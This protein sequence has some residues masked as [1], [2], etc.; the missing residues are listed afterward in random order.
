MHN[1]IRFGIIDKLFFN[2]GYGFINPDGDCENIF[3]LLSKVDYEIR[4]TLNIGSRVSFKT[5]PSQMHNDKNEAY[6][7]TVCERKSIF[8]H[9]NIDKL[10]GNGAAEL[11]NPQVLKKWYLEP[12]FFS[13]LKGGVPIRII[14]G[15]KGVGKTALFKALIEDNIAEDCIPILIKPDEIEDLSNSSDDYLEMVR[16][17][18]S[19]LYTIITHK[20]I[21]YSNEKATS[22]IA[23]EKL[24]NIGTTVI[25]YLASVL[26]K[27]SNEI[28]EKRFSVNSDQFLNMLNQ[29]F[30][31]Q[32]YIYVYLDD[33]D[34]GWSSSNNGT[35]SLNAMIN[36]LM[37]IAATN[38]NSNIRFRISITSVVYYSIKAF[39]HMSDKIN[40]NV[41]WMQ[42][43]K[44]DIAKMLAM[45]IHLFFNKQP[46]NFS[47][48][49]VEN[50]FNL[51]FEP[52]FLENGKWENVPFRQVI[53]SVVRDRPRDIIQLC[54]FAANEA[55]KNGHNKIATEDLANIFKQ[56]SLEKLQDAI[57]EFKQEFNELERLINGLKPDEAEIR[58]KDNP[59]R[60]TQNQLLNKLA[61][62]SEH[63]PF[64]YS[65]KE[66]SQEDLAAVL[67][68]TGFINACRERGN[69]IERVSYDMNRYIYNEF[70]RGDFLYEIDPAYRFAMVPPFLSG[71]PK[72]YLG[73][74]FESVK[75]FQRWRERNN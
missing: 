22:L 24:R 63:K 60:F 40:E 56:Y 69:H 13:H 74:E 47:S 41:I 30:F 3:F 42:W 61:K 36:A 35:Q 15:N 33:L 64:I 20:L 9:D 17:W 59:W 18:K 4:L 26:E 75:S 6:C 43:T 39:N 12:D 45:R 31:D 73:P 46:A 71:I 65:G 2:R 62:I 58:S 44:P 66:A 32:K 52:N 54:K 7:I 19:G 27:K 72:V 57:L 28:V 11:E 70:T 37:D 8:S 1:D 34:R 67:Y 29:S 14:A 23:N 16:K 51:I 25:T 48:I 50:I 10:F 53:L 5:R 38:S 68:K 49:V 21:S 55:R